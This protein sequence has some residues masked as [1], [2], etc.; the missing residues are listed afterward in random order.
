MAGFFCR[1]SYQQWLAGQRDDESLSEWEH[2]REEEINREISRIEANVTAFSLKEQESRKA[3]LKLRWTNY[4]KVL[5]ED[6][7]MGH[8]HNVTE[9]IEEA[10]DEIAAQIRVPVPGRETNEKNSDRAVSCHCAICLGV[11]EVGISVVWSSNRDCPHV[12]HEECVSAWLMTRQDALCPC[13]RQA[14]VSDYS[15]SCISKEQNDAESVQAPRSH[16]ISPATLEGQ[17]NGICPFDTKI[18]D[19]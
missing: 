2:Q 14:F 11:Y 17:G 16:S 13:C 9:K 19:R 1:R 8:C 5:T 4:M 12:F 3:L 15:S 7:F 18:D 10:D 6:D